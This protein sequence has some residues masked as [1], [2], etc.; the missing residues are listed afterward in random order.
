MWPLPGG[1]P[2]V[3]DSLRAILKVA[4]S[5]RSADEFHRKVAASRAFGICATTK[6]LAHCLSVVG[7]IE[8]PSNVS[9]TPSGR[10][11]LRGSPKGLQLGLVA[12]SLVCRSYSA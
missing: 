6:Q 3:D 4:D 11:Y 9:L 12:V 7:L 8:G 1:F 2:T 5:C 10:Q